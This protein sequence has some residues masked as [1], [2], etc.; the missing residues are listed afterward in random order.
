M[1]AA[2]WKT[3]RTRFLVK[4]MQLRADFS[5]TD[6]LGREHRG[7]R[8]DYLVESSDGVQRIAPRE[9]FEDAYVPMTLLDEQTVLGVDEFTRARRKHPASTT[10]LRRSS[11]HQW[12]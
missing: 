10:E 7:R 11:R 6:P 3:Y 8:G 12:M 1:K 4:A 9:F 2:E 5:F